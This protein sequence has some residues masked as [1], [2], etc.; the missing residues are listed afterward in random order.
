MLRE[1]VDNIIIRTNVYVLFYDPFNEKEN[2]NLSE[3]RAILRAIA[4]RDAELADKLIK[5]HLR[6]SHSVLTAPQEQSA[7]R[8]RLS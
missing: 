6:H 5:E 4:V 7:I 8:A 1:Y 3:H 2:Y